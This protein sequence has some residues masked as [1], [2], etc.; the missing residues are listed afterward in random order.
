[1]MYIV[2]TTTDP[3]NYRAG[4][5]KHF[6]KLG[7]LPSGA[8]VTGT[9]TNGWLQTTLQGE[10]CYLSMDYLQ[11]VEPPGVLCYTADD[12][13]QIISWLEGLL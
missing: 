12:I 5:G 6:Q 7:T 11:P 2:V 10:A 3:L 13:R 4:P 8:I 9:A 1:M